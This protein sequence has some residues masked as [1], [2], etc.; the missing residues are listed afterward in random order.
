M[1]K[2]KKKPQLKRVP[3]LKK[4]LVLR[5]LSEIYIEYLV[6]RK[7]KDKNTFI[8]DI[9]KRLHFMEDMRKH[10]ERELTMKDV[11][12]TYF[13]AEMTER[14]FFKNFKLVESFHRRK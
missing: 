11:R 2:R 4:G 3:E 8:C 1:A 10:G 6:L 14:E 12:G 13:L 9:Y 7:K 5:G